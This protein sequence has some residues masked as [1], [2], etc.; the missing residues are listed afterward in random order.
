MNPFVF[1][2]VDR[3]IIVLAKRLNGSCTIQSRVNSRQN[4]AGLLRLKKENESA[5]RH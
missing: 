2:L 3:A 1:E 5:A 4:A